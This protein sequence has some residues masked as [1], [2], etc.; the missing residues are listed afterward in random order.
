V[1]QPAMNSS[2][3]KGEYTCSNNKG[4]GHKFVLN[5]VSISTGTLTNCTLEACQQR[6]RQMQQ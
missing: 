4:T 3:S 6:P 1:Q 2:S 5:G